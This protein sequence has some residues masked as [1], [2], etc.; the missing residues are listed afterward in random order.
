MESQV[1][2]WASAADQAVGNNGQITAAHQKELM[3]SRLFQLVLGL[4]ENVG[5]IFPM[6]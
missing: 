3:G 2:K 1:S 5:L 6:K 4:S